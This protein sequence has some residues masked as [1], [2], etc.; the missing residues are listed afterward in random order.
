M[1]LRQPLFLVK[2]LNYEYWTWWV[3]YLP[4]MPYWLYQAWRTRSLT[5]FTAANPFIELGGFFGES[6]INILNHI[7]PQFK[8]KTLFFERGIA[9]ENLLKTI[10]NQQLSFPIIIKPNIGERGTQVAKIS[11]K[12]ELDDYLQ[13]N[14]ADFIVQEFI[15][16]GIE[17]GVLYSRLPGQS[18]G[19][20]SS[21]TLKEFLSVVGDGHS[22]IEELMQQNNR[23]RFQLEAMRTRLGVSLQQI[24]A[25]GEKKLLEP[26]GNHCR[27]TKFIN[28]N[29]KITPELSSVFDQVAANIPDFHYGRFDLKVKS[30]EDLYQGKNIRIMEL[31]GASSDPGH[32]YDPHYK[33]ID[34]YRDLA[35]HWRILAD[36][37]IEQHK[38]GI[39]P[40][41]ISEVWAAAKVHFW[42]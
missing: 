21:L 18:K 22:S 25:K 20:I 42:S 6:K 9:F 14:T 37:C 28:A 24:L 11:D 27:G 40:A 35:K 19:Q 15:D 4:M 30:W 26:I 33:L 31:N 12:K 38:K 23:A 13:Q 8:P 32:I 10:E 17:L 34:A 7:A 16:F 5:Y 1:K 36:I 39:Y 29:A 2:L 3:F 41:P